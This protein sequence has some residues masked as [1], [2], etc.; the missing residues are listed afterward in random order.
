MTQETSEA[1]P[2]DT[3][4]RGL[5][6]NPLELAF[7]ANGRGSP[8]LIFRIEEATA[9]DGKLYVRKI[10]TNRV[11]LQKERTQFECV[12]CRT[13]TTEVRVSRNIGSTGAFQTGPYHFCPRCETAPSLYNIKNRMPDISEHDLD[14]AVKKYDLEHT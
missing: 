13:P 7:K 8:R 14:M 6:Y 11:Y 1:E 12:S 5:T 10:D 2:P 4:P 9:P 3:D